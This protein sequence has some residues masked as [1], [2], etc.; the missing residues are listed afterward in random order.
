MG[1]SVTEYLLGEGHNVV[2]A[3][4]KPE[5]MG[6]L[7]AKYGARILVVKVDVQSQEDV[8]AAY[9][10]AKEHFGRIDVVYN[11]AG[12]SAVGEVEAVP[13][14]EAKDMFEVRRV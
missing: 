10:Q 14:A 1:L 5:S 2:A 11:N 13:M 9:T 12:Y 8:D 3:V 7:K 4:R 6:A